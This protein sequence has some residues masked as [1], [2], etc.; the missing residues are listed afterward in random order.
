MSYV[1]T[2]NKKWT[3]KLRQVTT[4]NRWPIQTGDY[5]GDHYKQVANTD[6]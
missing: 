2:M 1:I 5:T 6:R 4:I 3:T